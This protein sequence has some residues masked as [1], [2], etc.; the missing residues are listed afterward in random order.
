MTTFAAWQYDEL[1]QAGIDYENV[2]N[3]KN[4]DS[5]A[6]AFRNIKKENIEI[7]SAIDISKNQRIL[8][9]GCG[10]GSFAIEAAQHC[11]MVF[12]VDVSKTMLDA[13]KKKAVSKGIK[14]IEFYHAGF[15]TYKHNTDPLDAIVSQFALHHLPDFWKMI[16][17]K[18]IHD[19]LKDDGIFYLKDAVYSFD[20]DQYDGFFGALLEKAKNSGNEAFSKDVKSSVSEEFST[21]DWIMEAL[22]NKAG[23]LVEKANYHE[24]I[25]AQYICKKQRIE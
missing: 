17:L 5:K 16:A 14:N 6:G 8:E 3:V 20:V 1:K 4:Y 13:A 24:G 10:T 22:L 2:Q 11:N 25:L 23:F 12:A 21:L 7:M 18:S 9:F 19:M 15:L